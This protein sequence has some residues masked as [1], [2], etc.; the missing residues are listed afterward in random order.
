MLHTYLYRRLD[1]ILIRSM[2]M[3]IDKQRRD[4]SFDRIWS[5]CH[6]LDTLKHRKYSKVW[7]ITTNFLAWLFLTHIGLAQTELTWQRLAD[8]RFTEKYS[9]EVNANF[10]YPHFGAS[11]KELEG[12]EVYLKGFMLILGSKQD[13]FVLSRNPFAACFFCGAAGPESIVELK[14]RPDHPTFK[15]DQFVTIKGTLRLNQDDINQ[16]NYIL[17]EAQLHR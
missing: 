15:M 5:C 1:I 8:V 9:E 3:L 7:L 12:K 16:C 10:Y 2:K 14:L 11:V 13:F 4:F 17:E 6:H